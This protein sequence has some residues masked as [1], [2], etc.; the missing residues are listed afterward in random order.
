MQSEHPQ[1]GGADL[2]RFQ[3]EIVTHWSG[4]SLE[5]DNHPYHDFR[6]VS[7]DNRRG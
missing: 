1:T 2:K 6:V 3:D 7:W 5:Y 4:R